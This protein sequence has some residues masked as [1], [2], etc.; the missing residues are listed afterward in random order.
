[1]HSKNIYRDF[2]EHL[3]ATA[4]SKQSQKFDDIF[5]HNTIIQYKRSRVRDHFLQYLQPKSSILE[6]NC[7]TGDDAIYFAQH[8]HKVHATDISKGMQQVL[9][10]KIV[11]YNLQSNISNE[12]CSFTELKSLKNKGPYHAIFS[13]FAGLNCTANL[14]DV[15][16]SFNELLI[17]EGIVTLAIMPKFCL[18]ETLLICK[19]QIKIATRRFI[20]RYGSKAHVEGEFFNCSY[21]NASYIIKH[22]K[23]NFKLL[24]IEGLCT[25]V[26]PS[27]MLG[28]AEKY[29]S[30]FN[31][32]KNIE[33]KV[34]TKWPWKYM[35]DY[36][37]ISLQKI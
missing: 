8:N 22:L 29:P 3:V 9:Q 27:Y 2:N 4:F 34:K 30:L 28:F 12:L 13:N 7:G 21:Y 1:M 17:E 16:H 15:L 33:D 20:N 31:F 14:V 26:P 25:F 23:P 19:G 10:Q 35:G 36:Y 6:I 32:L 37:I 11:A 5:S 24:S 18:W